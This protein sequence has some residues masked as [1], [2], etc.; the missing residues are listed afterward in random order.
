MEF[1]PARDQRG[2]LATVQVLPFHTSVS[3]EIAPL[4]VGLLAPTAMQWDAEGQDTDTRVLNAAGLGVVTTV[5]VVPF[6]W[7]ASVV[8]LSPAWSE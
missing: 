7:A 6:H 1:S 3:G 8:S 5:Q 4:A 2:A